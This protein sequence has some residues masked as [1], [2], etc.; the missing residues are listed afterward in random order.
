MPWKL[1]SLSPWRISYPLLM[2]S[3]SNQK[4]G[5][6]ARTLSKPH[7]QHPN[8]VESDGWPTV[9][10]YILVTVILCFSWAPA[11]NETIPE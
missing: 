9:F 4:K 7:R 10:V 5:K 11:G 6:G 8:H 2:M 3:C 1:L